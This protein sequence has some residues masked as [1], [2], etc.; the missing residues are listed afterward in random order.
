MTNPDNIV[1]V[2][3]RNG[4]R[5]SVYEA[6]EWCQ[7]FGSGIMDGTG[8]VQNTVANMTVLVGGSSSKPDVL[9][10][11]NPAGYKIAL[12]IVGQQAVTITTPAS[13]SRISAIVAYTDDLALESTEDTVTGS[14][15]SC[16]LIVVNGTAAASPSAPTDTQIRSAITSDGATGSQASYAVIATIKVASNTTAITDSLITR[17]QS[18][19]QSPKIDFTTFCQYAETTSTVTIS[20]VG[21]Y[22]YKKING[23]EIT[24][25]VKTGEKYLLIANACVRPTANNEVYLLAMANGTTIGSSVLNANVAAYGYTNLTRSVKYEATADGSVVFSIYTGTGGNVNTNVDV[26][27]GASLAIIRIA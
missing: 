24:I 27:K 18:G 3:A 21:N 9:I 15:A 5:A 17:N 23:T 25:N 14:P 20:S 7:A 2:R 6:N 4:G 13:N 1:R 22:N 12:D 10:A 26:L 11:Q 19:V 8:V 16:G